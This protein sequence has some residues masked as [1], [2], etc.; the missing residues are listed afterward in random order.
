M[1]KN[2]LHIVFA[3][4]L[5]TTSCHKENSGVV[6]V[7]NTKGVYIINQGNFGFG[8]ADIS[9]Y[10]PDSV[11][12]ANNPVNGLFKGVNGYSL[13]DVA[14]SMY[15][16]DS[17]G[18]IVMNNSQRI[19]VVKIPSFKNVLTISLLH[20][21]PRYFLPINDSIAYVTELYQG[22]IHVINYRTGALVTQITGVAEWTEQMVMNGNNVVVEEQNFDDTT[23]GSLAVINAT[24]NTFM[25]R[26]KYPGGNINGMVKDAQGHIWLALDEDSTALIP[27][28]LCCLN[29]DMSINKVLVFSLGHHPN[30]L[31]IDGTGSQLYFFD[32]DIYTVATSSNSVPT[33]A[34]SSVNG[35]NFYALGVDPVKGDVYAADALDYVQPSRIYRYSSSGGLIQSFAAGVITGNFTFNE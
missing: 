17:L 13:G 14:Q 31:C 19:N 25:Q 28:S 3:L 9:F 23:F 32:T 4:L 26:Y 2:L 16:K 30:N 34:F 7:A 21:Y 1:K 22:E 35:Q 11:L 18:Y 15:I 10:N 5:I 27:A 24:T 20:A 29:S 33:T 6:T 8:N 12:G